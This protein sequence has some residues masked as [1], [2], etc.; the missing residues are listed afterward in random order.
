MKSNLFWFGDLNYRI[1]LENEEVRNK[2][3]TNLFLELLEHDQ[4]ILLYFFKRK[5]NS[6]Y[7]SQTIN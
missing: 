3:T 1:S 7:L 6:D 2:L 4:V 5:I